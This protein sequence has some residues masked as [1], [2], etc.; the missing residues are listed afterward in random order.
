MDGDFGKTV[1]RALGI[2][3]FYFFFTLVVGVVYNEVVISPYLIR[4]TADEVVDPDAPPDPRYESKT[5][6][7]HSIVSFAMAVGVIAAIVRTV[8]HAALSLNVVSDMPHVGLLPE[9]PQPK[10]F[11]PAPVASPIM[12]L[13]TGEPAPAPM[14]A[15]PFAQPTEPP[16]QQAQSQFPPPPQSLSQ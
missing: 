4:W 12:D 15:P 11:V 13:A 1:K 3:A 2:F 5:H 6:D 8:A 14:T 9:T 7:M 10:S 16:M